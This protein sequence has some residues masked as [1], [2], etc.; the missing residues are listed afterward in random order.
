MTLKSSTFF[1]FNQ[2]PIASSIAQGCGRSVKDRKPVGDVGCCDAW[3]GRE[4]PLMD[5]KV[6]EALSLSLSL[7]FL[8]S[9][10]LS[11]FIYLSVCLSVHL[12]L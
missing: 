1:F 7:S 9:L 10:N 2:K 8:D 11:L 6:A 12:S 3:D 5:R 4:N